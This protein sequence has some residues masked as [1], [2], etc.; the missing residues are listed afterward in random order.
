[1][2]FELLGL[3]RICKTFD[4]NLIFKQLGDGLYIKEKIKK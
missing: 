4:L 3:Y 1:M 2:Y